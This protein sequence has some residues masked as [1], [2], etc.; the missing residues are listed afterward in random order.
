MNQDGKVRGLP[1][2]AKI[3]MAGVLGV[4]VLGV[5]AYLLLAQ[6]QNEEVARTELLSV[7]STSA[8]T[9]ASSASSTSTP[10]TSMPT[11]SMPR[12]ASSA[13]PTVRTQKPL[14]IPELPFLVNS[15]NGKGATKADNKPG[16]GASGSSVDTGLKN[17]FK[18]FRVKPKEPTTP[19]QNPGGAASSSQPP[20]LQPLQPL[21]AQEP[22]V[23]RPTLIPP[24]NGVG[25]TPRVA[26]DPSPPKLVVL[27]IAPTVTKVT[28]P[29]VQPIVPR[30][31]Q[32]PPITIPAG[33]KLPNRP[34]GTAIRVIIVKP[35]IV[36]PLPSARAWRSSTPVALPSSLSGGT[37]PA[38][39]PVMSQTVGAPRPG[40]APPSGNATPNLSDIPDELTTT[41]ESDVALLT[42]GQKLIPDPPPP[43][44]PP[45]VPPEPSALEQL[46]STQELE[47]TSVVLGPVNTA[48]FKTKTGFLVVPL[49]QTLPDS[50]AVVK[51]VTANSATLQLGNETLELTLDRR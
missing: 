50:A 2:Q 37:L 18:P 45:P 7:S 15:P 16:V 1:R 49:G 12:T 27:P 14:T 30:M 17:P 34:S 10:T 48:I 9:P 46:V 8:Q 36:T 6:P 25:T 26:V 41:L 51:T 35:P 47:F 19:T 22:V 3:A 24:S 42:P 43:I 5:T 28:V 31:T 29:K 20:P 23:V 32:A 39:P 38:I 13:T 40:D 33:S 4:G 21:P 11:T 44:P